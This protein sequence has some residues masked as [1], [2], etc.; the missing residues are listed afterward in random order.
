MR[1]KRPDFTD[2]LLWQ[3]DKNPLGINREAGDQEDVNGESLVDQ[4]RYLY[5]IK[6][7][8]LDNDIKAMMKFSRKATNTREKRLEFAGCVERREDCL[9]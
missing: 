8:E 4:A 5:S 6:T 9:L 2:P 3:G 1:Q 7:K